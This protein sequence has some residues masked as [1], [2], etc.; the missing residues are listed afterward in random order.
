MQVL[1]AQEETDVQRCWTFLSLAFNMCQSIGLH[2]RSTLEKDEYAI[3]EAKR[4]AFWALYTIDKNISLNIGVTSHFQ[5]HDIDADLYTPS[6]DPKHRPWDLMGL[7]IVEFANVQG[8]VYD[9]L[10][11]TSACR[12]G[13]EQRSASIE[14]LSSDLMTVR[15]KLLAVRLSPVEVVKLADGFTRLMLV[16]VFMPT[17]YMGWQRVQTL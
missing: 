6:N 2:R 16:G 5:D 3:A 10:Y 12:A 13:D 1:K 4:H 9:Q 11:S 14:R 17:P 7:V 8:R 15:D